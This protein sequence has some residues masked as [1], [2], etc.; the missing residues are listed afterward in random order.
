M[1]TRNTLCFAYFGDG[2][3][4]GWYADTFG[5]IR[6]SPK[7]YCESKHQLETIET[8]FKY[9][10]EKTKTGESLGI[11]KTVR[12][13]NVV[14]AALIDVG[15]KG[16]AAILSKYDVVELRH[17]VSPIY[18]GPDPTFDKAACDIKRALRWDLF[19]AEGINDLPYGDERNKRAREFESRHPR[20]KSQNWVSAD[21][22]KVKE[23]AANEPTEF[24]GKFTYER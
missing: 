1:E 21:Q 3:F 14:A 22:D 12:D 15:T 18:D 9:K 17:V 11:V 16:D 10:L 8:N 23:W 19:V 5:S 4:L 13:H 2:Q 20:I 7:L 6:K 24:I